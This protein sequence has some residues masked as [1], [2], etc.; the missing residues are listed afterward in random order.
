MSFSG[1]TI[2]KNTSVLLCL[3]K[4]Q[5]KSVNLGTFRTVGTSELPSLC[6]M[7]NHLKARSDGRLLVVSCDCY[8]FETL[9]RFQMGTNSE[10]LLS[11]L[12]TY[13]NHK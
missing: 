1:L 12:R 7:D 13:E 2:N 11:A 10:R 5:Q 4:N 6:N 3:L 8:I 9:A